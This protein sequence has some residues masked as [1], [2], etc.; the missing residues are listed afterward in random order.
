MK[1][2]PS[3]PYGV[4][5]AEAGVIRKP[6]PGKF[7][8]GLIFPQRYGLAMSNLGYQT[9]YRQFNA[10]DDVVCERF[11]LPDK[12]DGKLRSIESDRPPTDFDMLAFSVSFE[13]DYPH[14]LH[15]LSRA[16]LPLLAS[17]RTAAHPL[18]VIGGIAAMLN[19]E[20]LAPF[21]DIILIGEA[22][23]I[24]PDFMDSYRRSPDRRQFLKHAAETAPGTYL[25]AAYAITYDAHGDIATVT[26]DPG[27]P[28]TVNLARMPDVERIDTSST[29]LTA[30]TTFADTCL[31]EVSR[32]CPHGC[33]FCSAGFIYRP[34]RFRDPAFLTES[35]HHAMTRAS[36]VGLVGAAVS[37]YPDLSAICQQFK[38]ADLRF[39]FSSLRADAL[40]D[41]LLQVLK[42]N[43]TK[44]A[45]IAPEAG[46][47]RMRNVINKG[48]TEDAILCAADKIVA[49]GIPNL[50]LYFLVG[51]PTETEEDIH[52]I[53]TLCRQIKSVFLDASRQQKRIGTITVHTNAFI[54]KP[55][56]PFQW[57]AMDTVAALQAKARILRNGLK[58]IANVRFQMGKIRDGYVQ[59][60]L[61]RGDRRVADLL[62]QRHHSG[63]N[64]SQAIKRSSL[65]TAAYVTRQRDRDAIL[66][67]DFIETGI[68]K[69]FLWHDYQKALQGRMTPPC[70]PAGCTRCGACPA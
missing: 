47:Q 66:P 70:P 16:R 18:V 3:P 29:V 58:T 60:V 48:L 7:H 45:T 31:I 4:A 43:R 65:E 35:I 2:H 68:S 54:P 38:G 56:T 41:D 37:D 42:A 26:P 59:A 30:E 10:F 21:A 22:E 25:P 57:T 15:L 53:V 23:A 62:L 64:W 67:W 49:A 11:C 36:R 5:P 32:G 28:A 9:V 46:S 6:W 33:R 14:I 27:F 51:L 8:V 40:T 39:S 19:P 17:E 12:A 20:P 63:G 44:T 13:N 55:A 34:T 50:K 69:S 61:S 24:L 1:K 52:A